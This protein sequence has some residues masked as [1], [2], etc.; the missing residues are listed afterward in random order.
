MTAPPPSVRPPGLPPRASTGPGPAPV[1]LRLVPAALGVW[2][3]AWFAIAWPVAGA[4]AIGAVAAVAALAVPVVAS[5]RLPPGGRLRPTGRRARHRAI[6]STAIGIALVLAAISVTAGAVAGHAHARASGWWGALV[7]QAATVEVEAVVRDSPAPVAARPEGDGTPRIR[8]RAEVREVAGRGAGAAA[9]SPVL[10][11]GPEAWSDVEVG[12]RLRASGRLAPVSPE[13]DVTALLLASGPPVVLDGGTPVARAVASMRAGLLEASSGLPPDAAGLVPGIAVG[14]TSR[15]P[16]ALEDAMKAVSLTHLTA[17]SGA[18]VA[19]L[20]AGVLVLTAWLPRSAR[21]GL[22]VLTLLFFVALVQPGPSVLRAATMGAVVVLGILLGRP[23]RAAPALAGAVVVLVL[24]DP[25]IARSFGFA[26]SVLATTGLILLA[27]ALAARWSRFMP[28]VLAHA[29]AVPTAAQAACGPVVILLQPSVALLAVPANL[30]SAAAV[31]P[32]TIFGV[33]ATVAGPWW[34]EAARLLAVVAGWFAE[35][36]AQ[37]ARRMADMPGSALPWLP[38]VRGAVLLALLTIAAGVALARLPWRRRSVRIG[39][40]ALLALAVVLVLPGGPLTAIGRWI[41]GAWPPRDWAVVAC[42][43]GQGTAVAVRSGP[44]AAVVVDSGPPGDAARRCLDA[45]GVRRVDLLV[46]THLHEDHIGGLAGVLAGREVRA[47]IVGPYLEPESARRAVTDLLGAAGIPVATPVL[48]DDGAPSPGSPAAAPVTGRAG[49]VRWD[50]LSPSERALR[51]AVGVDGTTL[52]DLGASV[53]L[54]GP[55]ISVLALGD[56]ETEAQAALARA[57]RRARSEDPGSAVALAQVDVA[58]M[59]HHG[60]ARQDPDLADLV[61]AD[62]VLV[63]VGENT[64]GHPAPRA[65]ALYEA[66]GA[67]VLRTDTCGAVAVVARPLATVSRC[68]RRSSGSPARG[69][70]RTWEADGVPPQSR[71]RRGP[72]AATVPWDQVSPAPV[73]LVRG[74]ETVLAD[75][76]VARVVAAVRAGD[77][78]A[79]VT[80][81]EAAAGTPGDLAAV[82]SPSLFGEQRCVVVTGVEAMSDAFAEEALAYLKD[83]AP[84]VTLVLRHAGGIRGKKLLDAV[85]AAG[86]PV[87]LCEAVKRDADK[88]DLVS[89][90]FRRLGRRVDPEAVRALVNAVG[91]DLAELLAAC[92]QLAGDTEGRVSAAAVHRY[93]GG[94]VEATGFAVADAA[95][96]GNGAE[97]IRLLRHALATGTDPVPLVAAL[98]TK[99]RTMAKVA[100]AKGRGLDPVRDLGLASWQVDRAH[101]ELRGWTPEGLAAAITAVATADAE[102]KGA[103]RDPE[104]AVERAVLHIAA[105]RVG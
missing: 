27:P 43:V 72:A 14:D 15:L 58:L 74:S 35:W 63:S 77:P 76:A 59:A 33:L 3:T 101:R 47:A 99:V 28:G 45:L 61:D 70:C 50:V 1:D 51:S 65:I 56:L 10:V 104:F 40:A 98:A 79:D 57:V 2:A 75:R 48:P 44:A 89:A 67:V 9:R 37:V 64:Y 80:G 19:I 88:S 84:D 68:R 73:V 31:P 55:E 20:L 17:V 87:V 42:D 39:G 100:A 7:R 23:A 66:T 102:V 54:R 32:A 83:P 4:L 85:A 38:G 26:L 21:A 78:S 71:S 81:L 97:A 82:T 24:V 11:L 62:L 60:S 41:P 46:L 6:G 93:Y 30:L 12:Q 86:F 8:V 49:D 94:R 52:N 22:A 103:A 34:P 36:I 18:H 105:A 92:S 29:L 91:S 96:L 5:G 53:L 95:V 90:E 69:G 13:D 16:P 25:W